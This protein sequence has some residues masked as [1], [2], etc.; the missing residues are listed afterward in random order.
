MS[1]RFLF[2]RAAVALLVLELERL[3]L[4]ILEVRET[5]NIFTLPYR[6]G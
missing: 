1:Y 3:K 6:G 2:F 5:G 4:K